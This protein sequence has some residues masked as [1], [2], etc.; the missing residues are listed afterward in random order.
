MNRRKDIQEELKRLAPVLGKINA[1]DMYKVPEGYFEKSASAIRKKCADNPMYAIPEGYFE[2][3]QE[4]VLQQVRK[5]AKTRS[6]FPQWKV[7]GIAASFVLI[8]SMLF[9]FQQEND[10]SEPTFTEVEETEGFQESEDYLL[11]HIDQFDLADLMM[12][13]MM[14]LDIEDINAEELELYME[15]NIDDYNIYELGTLL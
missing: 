2:K 8:V 1:M 11:N 9:W 10:I 12:E 7:M 15:E 5:P 14:D 6:L 4:D 13:E 3:M